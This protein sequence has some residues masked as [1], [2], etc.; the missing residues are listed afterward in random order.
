M[1]DLQQKVKSFWERP[2]GT[3]GK[4][5]LALGVGVGA[6]ATWMYL[7]IILAWVATVLA[8]TL[9]C[10]LAGG[11]LVALTSPIW[12]ST[13]GALSKAVLASIVRGITM[14]FTEIDP[15]G[16]MKNYAANR[17]RDQ[18]KL[19]EQIGVVEGVAQSLR[20][21]IA[22]NEAE[23]TQAL[24]IAGQAQ[25]QGKRAAL[26]VSSQ[27]AGLLKES[28]VTYQGLLAMTEK[29]IAGLNKLDEICTVTI[30]QLD[31]TIQ[32][33]VERRKMIRGAYRAMNAAKRII[34]GS[35]DQ[36]LFAL[37]A[38]SV[39][40]DFSAKFGEIEQF[41]KESAGI[42]E[43]YDITTGV[44]QEDALKQ[45]EL[46][47]K[48]ADELL[49]IPDV[50]TRVDAGQLTAEPVYV[51]ADGTEVSGGTDAHDLYANNKK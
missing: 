8:S 27:K 46:L 28:N 45:L 39:Q 35:E 31:N 40:N 25:K 37:A 5:L 49:A 32:Q 13:M 34:K 3:T 18:N 11:A 6:V 38:E 12:N 36:A 20:D 4:V 16:I 41:R 24:K 23:R 17:R 2:E 1:S 15:I 51:Q 43:S 21:T 22:R 47:D 10:V 19:K 48:R 30:G 44:F 26:V 14:F 7:P 33:Q 29:Q 42:F 9:Y 50:H